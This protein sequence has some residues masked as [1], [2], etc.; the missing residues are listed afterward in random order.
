MRAGPVAGGA[1][2]RA[3]VCAARVMLVVSVGALAAACSGDGEASD[4]SDLEWPDQP[5]NTEVYDGSLVTPI[6]T[7]ALAASDV[8]GR[9]EVNG[10]VGHYLQVLPGGDRDDIAEFY[11]EELQADGWEPVEDPAI[12]PAAITTLGSSW[13]NEGLRLTVAYTTFGD[14]EL[15]VLLGSAPR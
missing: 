4:L 13:E 5:P 2:G 12:A 8:Y 9:G 7:L 1:A 3:I 10:I 14:V 11:D 15:V 6:D